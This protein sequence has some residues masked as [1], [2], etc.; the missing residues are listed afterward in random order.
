[1]FFE[2]EFHI[3]SKVN[4]PKEALWMLP[5]NI[6]RNYTCLITP[7]QNSPCVA[8][9]KVPLM[10]RLFPLTILDQPT[11][12]SP[13]KLLARSLPLK[14]KMPEGQKR[15]LLHY[16][17]H[18]IPYFRDISLWVTSFRVAASFAALSSSKKSSMPPGMVIVINFNGVFMGLYS[19]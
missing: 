4:Y 3:F 2:I 15:S 9:C 8:P 16:S 12:L 7:T 10:G 1:M 5:T 14:G 13:R 6:G 11:N 18:S 19:A 17:N